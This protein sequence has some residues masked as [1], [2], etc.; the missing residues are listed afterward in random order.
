MKRRSLLKT[1]AAAAIALGCSTPMV[2][3]QEVTLRLHQFLPPPA[4]VPKHILKPWAAQVEEAA[5]GKLKIEHYDAMSLGGKP[6]ELM[7]QAIDGVA[8]ITMTV[9]GYTPGRFPKTEVFELP[10]MMTNPVATSKAFQELVETDLQ[11]GEYK[12]VKVLGAWVHGP[13]VIHTDRGVN[14]L[15]DM[16]GLKLRGPTRVINDMLS[17]LGATPVGMPLPAIPEALSKGVVSGTVIPWEVT[18]AVKLSQLVTY[19]TEFTGDEALYTATIILVMNKAKYESLPD[20]IRAAI[21]AESGQKLSEMAA[22]VM[23]DNDAP[24]RAIAEK[25]GNT[26][27][28]L[29]AEEV[30]RFKEASKPVIERWVSEM[31]SKDIDG[32]ALIEQAKALIKKHGG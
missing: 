4:T 9:V 30:A 22:Q 14:K 29:S 7:D 11:D 23:W 27:V 2:A 8:D 12:D 24:G 10:F 31:G 20:D 17:E 16:S 13:G 15:E 21:D 28:Q 6:P 32:N 25:A 1:A 18:P 5:G 19:H 3:A 26:I